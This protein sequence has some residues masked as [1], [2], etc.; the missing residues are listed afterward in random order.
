MPWY[1]LSL[2]PGYTILFCRSNYEIFLGFSF[3]FFQEVLCWNQF[4]SITL[5]FHFRYL[6]KWVSPRLIFSI[7][8]RCQRWDYLLTYFTISL[9][10][11]LLACYTT[12]KKAHKS[13]I[14]IAEDALSWSWISH[15]L[16]YFFS[17]IFALRLCLIRKPKFYCS[18]INIC[19]MG[20]R[21]WWYLLILSI[22]SAHGSGRRK[23]CTEILHGDI[24]RIKDVRLPT[25]TRG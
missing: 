11:S 9:I 7:Q 21:M 12:I 4:A 3:K 18:I 16:F 10:R 8:K 1:L 6:K 15:D 20:F 19:Y 14:D 2:L 17:I 25:I 5:L 22:W 13:S 23:S 24:A